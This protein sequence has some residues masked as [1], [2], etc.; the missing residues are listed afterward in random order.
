MRGIRDQRRQREFFCPTGRKQL[1]LDPGVT[2]PL[3]A[4]LL[5][6]SPSGR[7]DKKQG[8]CLPVSGTRCASDGISITVMRFLFFIIPA[9]CFAH[10]PSIACPP[11]DSTEAS[12]AVL[13]KP[14]Q[15]EL[16][17]LDLPF[18]LS[19]GFSFPSIHQSIAVTASVTQGAHHALKVLWNPDL[20]DRSPKGLMSNRRLGGLCSSILILDALLPFRGWAHEEGHRAVLTRR[21]ISS[22]N[23]IYKNPFAEM[24]SVSHVRDEDL[25]M[26]KGR[27]PA[28]MVR[29][30]EAGGEAQLELVQRMRKENFFGGRSSWL[31]LPDWWIN[32]GTLAYYIMLCGSDGA[33]RI[34]EEET[35]KEDA[36]VLKRDVVGGDYLS[37]VYDLFRPDEPYLSGVRGRPHPSGTGVDRYIQPSELSSEE[38][39]YLRLQGGLIL[40]NFLSPQMF[41]FNRFRGTNPFTHEP[42]W[43]NTALT[44]HPASFGTSTRL[45]VFYQEGALN[46][47][48]TWENY[49]SRHRYWPGLSA[50]LLQYPLKIGGK[51]IPV[52]ASAS[53]WLQPQAQ[54]F[55]SKRAQA[56][57]GLMFRAVFPFTRALSGFLEC[58]AKTAGWMPGN[59]YLEPAFQARAGVVFS[60]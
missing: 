30:A 39:R 19:H 47:V 53:V 12:P 3:G 36:D 16:P 26:L 50:E 21:D 11:S 44:H 45:H 28:D 48:L 33:N 9:V 46:L 32:V 37:W 54:R 55:D 57:C 10:S 56:G 18:N 31:D 23:D 34:I 49:F 58:N 13:K 14:L 6:D 5:K 29:L 59:V 1:N 52:C 17:L 15:I 22:R 60:L 8:K 38:L 41:G 4:I 35:L 40:L 24:V 51:M 27:H 20:S 7:L 2:A 42:F 43:W 25:A